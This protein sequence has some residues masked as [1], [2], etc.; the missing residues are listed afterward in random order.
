MLRAF[1]FL[2]AVLCFVLDP[3][4]SLAKGGGGAKIVLKERKFDF[5]R[6]DQWEMIEHAFLFTN[7][8][9]ETLRIERVS[10]D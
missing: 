8:G 7:Q 4:S 2:L 5:G 3:A 1:V 9:E 10:P 6:V